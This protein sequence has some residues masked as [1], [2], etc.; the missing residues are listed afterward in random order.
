MWVKQPS[1]KT[2]GGEF[3]KNINFKDEPKGGN[4]GGA[5]GGNKAGGKGPFKPNNAGKPSGDGKG[6]A[7]KGK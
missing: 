5:K 7:P 2:T 6:N 4:K 3:M 1:F